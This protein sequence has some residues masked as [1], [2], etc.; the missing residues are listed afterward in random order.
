ML[1][2]DIIFEGLRGDPEGSDRLVEAIAESENQV[3]AFKLKEANPQTGEFLTSRHSFFAPI[4]GLQEGYTNVQHIDLGGTIRSMSTW[5]LLAGDTVRSLSYYLACRYSPDVENGN[6]PQRQ[7]IDYTPTKFA[8]VPYDSIMQFHSQI[9][10]RIVLRH[11]FFRDIYYDL[12]THIVILF[13][14]GP[15]GSLVIA[16]HGGFHGSLVLDLVGYGRETT[17]IALVD[18]NSK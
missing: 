13:L 7:L 11:L 10:N 4:D 2:I 14:F 12:R 18:D 16:Q 5:H 17:S 9:E 1:G 8:V 6:P 15:V 3:L